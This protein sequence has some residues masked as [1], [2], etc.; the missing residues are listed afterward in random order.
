MPTLTQLATLGVVG[1]IAIPLLLSSRERSLRKEQINAVNEIRASLP[2]MT[3]L[4]GE[5]DLKGKA[6][7]GLAF[8]LTGGNSFLGNNV[9]MNSFTDVK[10]RTS[11][12]WNRMV[13]AGNTQFA[14]WFLNNGGKKEGE[15]KES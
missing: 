1:G 12:W 15:K 5:A 7:S 2:Q 11:G 6:D 4:S 3:K 8:G 9:N 14:D 10:D 13:L